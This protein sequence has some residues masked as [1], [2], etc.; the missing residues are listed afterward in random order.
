MLDSPEGVC[1]GQ[2]GFEYPATS[3]PFSGSTPR[4]V[5]G[6]PQ[7]CGAVSLSR[8][9]RSTGRGV[10]TGSKSGAGSGEVADGVA[11]RR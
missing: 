5:D 11:V 1:A 10:G 8:L 2:I 9:G 4:N 7:S 3:V 6:G